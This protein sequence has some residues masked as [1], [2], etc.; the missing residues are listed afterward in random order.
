MMDTIII[1]TEPQAVVIAGQETSQVNILSIGE[2]GPQGATGLSGTSYI[3][4]VLS[5]SNLSGHRIV[6]LD[7][8]GNA[9]YA[10]ADNFNHIG[11]VVGITTSATTAGSLAEIRTMG[12]FEEPSW[13][14]DINFPIYLGIEGLIT[15]ATPSL[16]NSL[17]SQIVGYVIN[18]TTIYIQ[19]QTPIIMT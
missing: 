19:L 6:Y 9:Q 14:F 3:P 10:S 1:T 4:D 16:P 17:F 18:P 15:Q 2:Q 11:K 5:G 12:K 8:N 7:I 13:N